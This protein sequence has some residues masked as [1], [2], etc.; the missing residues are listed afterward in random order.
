[1][2]EEWLTNNKAQMSSISKKLSES[3]DKVE[4][5]YIPYC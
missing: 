3:R 4:V 1:M 2:K 5:N